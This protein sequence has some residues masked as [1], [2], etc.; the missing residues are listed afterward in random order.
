M[1]GINQA[2]CW[3]VTVKLMVGG[4]DSLPALT[5]S[6]ASPLPQVLWMTQDLST[7]RTLWERA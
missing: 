1:W 7:T 6:R 2:E 4:R 3:I 5:P